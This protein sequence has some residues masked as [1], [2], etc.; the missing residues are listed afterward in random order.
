MRQDTQKM[1]SL[2][3]IILGNQYVAM[4]ILNKCEKVLQQIAPGMHFE[5]ENIF[6]LN[7]LNSCISEYF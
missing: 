4:D 5:I 3:D 7:L 6:L 1:K 2:R